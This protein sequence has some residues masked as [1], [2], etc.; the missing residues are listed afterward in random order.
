MN[1]KGCRRKQSLTNLRHDIDIYREGL[2][3]LTIASVA[4][5]IRTV[6]YLNTKS[7]A[8]ILICTVSLRYSN[9]ETRYTVKAPHTLCYMNNMLLF[10]FSKL[11]IR[12]FSWYDST[13]AACILYSQIQ[14]DSIS[15]PAQK[16][17]PLSSGLR[18]DLFAARLQGRSQHKLYSWLFF[19][20]YIWHGPRNSVVSWLRHYATSRKVAGSIPDEI[21]GFFNWPNPYSRT[22]ALESSQPLTEMSTRNLLGGKRRPERKADNLTAICEPT[23]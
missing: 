7:R 23:V 1:W 21:I 6:Y 11:F 4:T 5:E 22:M 3:N 14:R 12:D 15:I 10:F 19:V 8:Y 2:R 18:Y 20:W 16:V 9:E 17:A 13:K